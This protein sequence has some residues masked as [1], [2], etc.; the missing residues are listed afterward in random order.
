MINLATVLPLI[1][2]LAAQLG[3]NEASAGSAK[4]DFSDTGD[5]LARSAAVEDIEYQMMVQRAAQTAI[6]AMP[7]AGMVDFIK[8]TQR[9]LGR[10]INDIV[11]LERPFDSNHGFLWPMM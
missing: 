7:A 6:W 2:V 1:F 9:D 11:Y 10:D 8:G 4:N 3:S 5:I